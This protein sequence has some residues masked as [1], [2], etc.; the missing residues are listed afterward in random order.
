MVTHPACAAYASPSV[1]VGSRA[2]MAYAVSVPE[3][4][5]GGCP[6]GVMGV[7]SI[8]MISPAGHTGALILLRGLRVQCDAREIAWPGGKFT[9]SVK[10]SAP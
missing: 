10:D 7:G 9:K 3:R 4:F 1:T 5:R 6:F 8:P 2:A